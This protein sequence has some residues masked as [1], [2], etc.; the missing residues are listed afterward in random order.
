GHRI[1]TRDPPTQ[2][3]AAPS[4]RAPRPLLCG[5]RLRGH[6]RV[7][8]PPHPAL[9]RRR[10]HRNGQP[11]AALPVP[12][13][14]ASPRC[15]HHHRTRRT[16]RRHR[17]R[18]PPTALGVIGPPT[19]HTPTRSRTLPGAHRRTRR[20]VVVPTLPTTTTTDNQ[21]T[22]CSLEPA[23]QPGLTRRAPSA[24]RHVAHWRVPELDGLH[25][26]VGAELGDEE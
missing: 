11:R 8:R 4:P 20:L 3:S 17:Q 18:R 16:P 9:G 12:S 14:G 23:P 5:A 19:D 7:T 10:P 26:P 15:H 21:L 22:A 24:D 25:H 6:P 1:G 2:P 13:P